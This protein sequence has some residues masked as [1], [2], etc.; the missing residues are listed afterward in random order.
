MTRWEY[1]IQPLADTGSANAGGMLARMGR[2]GWELI[3]IWHRPDGWKTYYF[4][5]PLEE[6]PPAP[7]AQAPAPAAQP[8]TPAEQ[9]A[10]EAPTPAEEPAA[11]S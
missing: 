6:Q 3:D 9:P 5:R 11:E 2:Q 7:V 8:A 10:A 1:Y 4:K